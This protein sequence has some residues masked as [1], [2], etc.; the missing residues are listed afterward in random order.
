MKLYIPTKIFLPIA[1]CTPYLPRSPRS[2]YGN[3][4][5]TLFTCI[6]ITRPVLEYLTNIILPV[7]FFS[8]PSFFPCPLFNPVPQVHSTTIL[9]FFFLFPVAYSYSILS[10]TH[11][12]TT[13]NTASCLECVLT[14]GVNI[15]HIF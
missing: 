9:S 4:L 11:T 1:L 10:H 2:P 12:V 15:Y 14:S 3:F 7:P 8:L 13:L 5:P 6:F